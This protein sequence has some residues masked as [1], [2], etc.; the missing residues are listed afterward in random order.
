MLASIASFQ[1]ADGTLTGGAGLSDFRMR[2]VRVFD[3]VTPLRQA[4][5]VPLDRLLRKFD[6]T[7]TVKRVHASIK[8]S[9]QYIQS[10]EATVPQSGS[11]TLISASGATWFLLNGVLI[12]H[13]LIDEIGATTYHSYHIVGG[14]LSIGS[15][16][17]HIT[18]QRGF[19]TLT[20]EPAILSSSRSISAAHGS[21]TLTGEPVSFNITIPIIALP[22][23]FVLTGEPVTLTGGFPPLSAGF[24]AFTLT[25][26]TAGLFQGAGLGASFGSFALTGE[27]VTFTIGMGAVLMESSG[28]I[29]TEGSNHILME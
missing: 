3:V 28:Y 5:P 9:E 21:F 6:L 15:A 8:A 7:F 1:L 29:L 19:F 11:V 16:A 18:A 2:A 25:G 27:P 14:P 22:G 24:G 13:E 4:N 17:Y 12:S 10:H 26:Q 23:T 20:G